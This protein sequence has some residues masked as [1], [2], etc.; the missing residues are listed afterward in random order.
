MKYLIA[1]FF[2]IVVATGLKAQIPNASFESWYT[3]ALGEYPTGWTT[4][5]SVAAALGGGNNVF[6]GNDPSDGNLSMHL[7]SVNTTF[8]IKGPGMA[9]NGLVEF[10]GGAFVFS[11]GSPDT[12]RSRF[13]NGVFKYNPTNPNDE[14]QISVTLLR[15]SA[16]VKDTIAY[17]VTTFNGAFTTYTP[18]TTTLNY[19]DWTHNPDTCL[20]IIQSSRG[21][22]DV[23]LGV[24]TELV[25]DTLNFTGTVG[26]EEANDVINLVNIFPTPAHNQLTI[27]VD[28]KRKTD[29]NCTIYDLTGR[30]VINMPFN[31]NKETIDISSLAK[32][33]YILKLSD[34]NNKGLY[35]KNFIK[36]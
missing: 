16:G 27:A 33:N 3:Y 23:N 18:F 4:S 11:G 26:I 14:G 25:I 2:P 34:E 1:L 8:G 9:T 36:D 17:G 31:S 24:G 10:S 19:Y 21:I 28:L 5:D 30:Q 20:I 6:K 29:L 7:K 35:S 32:G 15:D 12:V 13:L 22:N